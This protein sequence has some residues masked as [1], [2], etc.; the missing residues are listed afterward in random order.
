MSGAINT[1]IYFIL[2]FLISTGTAALVEDTP[3]ETAEKYF[4]DLAAGKQQIFREYD[5]KNDLME[6]QKD[7]TKDLRFK[8]SETRIRGDVAVARVRL[9]T[10]D[11]SGVQKAYR[12]NS[13]RYVMENLYSES[14]GDK[15]KL[16]GSCLKI[17]K[18]QVAEAAESEGKNSSE[19]FM[20]MEKNADG[21]WQVIM[22][23]ENRRAI[24]GGLELP[25]G[26]AKEDTKEDLSDKLRKDTVDYV[27]QQEEI[28]AYSY[29]QVQVM[30][31]SKPSG[32]TVEDLK[33]VTRYK[34]VGTEE[35]LY[36]LEQNYNLNCLL[37][38]A[39]ASHESAYGTMQFHPN[40]VCGYGYSGFS[41]INDCLDTVGRVL[42]KNYL[43]SSGPYYKGN[44]IDSV[45]RTYA[46]DPS[47][48]SK[49]ARKVAYF[50][51]IISENHN[52]QLEKLK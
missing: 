40:N 52:R 39:I 49:V 11:F 26:E 51:E 5:H 23:H 27:L 34:L 17:Y 15:N 22:T 28:P 2:S 24:M 42:A 10:G 33:M 3:E 43:D 31:M 18:D 46:A 25:G 44:T 30:D 14:I 48:D 7:T 32:V 13:Y 12:Q 41:S 29:D 35:K 16:A 50:Y 4:A 45:N 37:L 6:I 47:W 9:T 21:E 1:I 36:E 8:I 20:A 38:L 19:I